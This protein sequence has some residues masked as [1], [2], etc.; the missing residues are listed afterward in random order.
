MSAYREA[1][2]AA[3]AAHVTATLLFLNPEVSVAVRVPA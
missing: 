1:L 3:S 2:T